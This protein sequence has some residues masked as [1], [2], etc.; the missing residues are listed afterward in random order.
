[1]ANKTA[2]ID[3]DM[4]LEQKVTGL[5]L[6]VGHERHV[7]MTRLIQ[8]TGVSLLQLGL[9][10]AL[11]YAPEEGL[12]VNQLKAL[13]IDD[14]PNV[15]RALNKLVAAGLAVKQRSDADQRVV[16]LKITDAGRQTHQD[17]DSSLMNMQLGLDAAEQQQLF[18]L[19]KKL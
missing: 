13:M 19:L 15:S 6:C 2:I 8:H 3:S 18:D 5:L 11:D 10:H 1:M 4:S 17:A 9:L 16:F 12:T 14:S 7:Q